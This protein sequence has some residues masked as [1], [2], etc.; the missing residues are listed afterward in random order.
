MRISLAALAFTLSTLAVHAEAGTL[1]VGPTGSGADFDNV[2]LAVAAASAGDVVLV[3]AG[4]YVSGETLLVDKPITLLGAGADQTALVVSTSP[5]EAAKLPLRITGIAADQKLVVAGFSLESSQSMN[6]SASLMLEALDCAGP[7]VLSDL[8]GAEGASIVPGQGFVTLTNC[9]EVTLDRCTLPSVLAPD[10]SVAE[11]AGLSVLDSNVQINDS[12]IGGMASTAL[13]PIKTASDGSPGIR[14]A[15]SSVS[16]S[17]SLVRGGNGSV[18]FLFISPD[19]LTMGGPGVLVESGTLS[20]RGGG[21]SVRGGSGGAA[22][23]GA[24]TVG[25]AGAAG[26]WVATGAAVSTAADVAILAGADFGGPVTSPAIAGGG[27]QSAFAEALATLASSP[28]LLA[29]GDTHTYTFGGPPGG[30]ALSFYSFQQVSPFSLAGVEGHVVLDPAALIPLP[31]R[32]LDAA[33]S[34]SLP[35]TVPPTA[36]LVGATVLVQAATLAPSGTLSVSAP[37]FAGVH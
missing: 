15:G 25:G 8:K 23:I 2:A 20:L 34:A 30:V 3:A 1:T 9:G 35:T 12:N 17:R 16:V 33:G 11:L 14:V 6:G 18:P 37:V 19:V 10:V 36:S 27:A 29:P 5:L 31:K 21:T 13:G 4:D 7:L 22:V 24:Q 32:T 28:K 26:V